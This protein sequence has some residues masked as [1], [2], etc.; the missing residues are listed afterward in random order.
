MSSWPLSPQAAAKELLRRRN[1]RN[2]L[3]DYSRYTYPGYVPSN[4][5]FLIADALERV[6]GGEIKRLMINMPPRHG[7][8]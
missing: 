3:I 5:H 2:Y 8:S 7:K 6:A 1:A 4:H